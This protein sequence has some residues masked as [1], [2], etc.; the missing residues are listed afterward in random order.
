MKQFTAEYSLRDKYGYGIC[1]ADTIEVLLAILS[2]RGCKFTMREM[3]KIEAWAEGKQK[4][5]YGAWFT[6]RRGELGM[7]EYTLL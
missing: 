2:S 1:T 5:Y 3:E 6:I 4:K 7:T